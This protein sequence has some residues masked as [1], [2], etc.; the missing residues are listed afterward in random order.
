MS[1]TGPDSGRP[2]A[3]GTHIAVCW[4]WVDLEGDVRRAGVSAAD[5]AALE[6]ALEIAASL[7]SGADEHAAPAEVVVV[8][9]GPPG[10]DT[11][12]REA[13]AAGA[14][15]AVR[16]DGSTDLP[17]DRVAA[18]LAGVLRG[19]DFVVCGD[20]SPDRGSG[21]VPAFLA[22]E[23]GAAQ[24][25]GLIQLAVDGRLTEHGAPAVRALRRLDGGRR[26]QLTVTAPAVLSVEGSVATLRRA[27]LPAQLAAKQ[28][29]IEVVDGPE[30]D[31]QHAETVRPFRPRPRVVPAPEGDG[32]LDRIRALTDAGAAV[33]H[34]E[35]VTLEPPEAAARIV[36]ALTEWGYLEP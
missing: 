24:A 10:A 17:S 34:G 30:A 21:S 6:T 36:V 5:K 31:D 35:T 4:K 29:V 13:V 2:A 20:Y 25:L 32:A 8:A 11:V 1:D 22:G 9:L 14:H 27:P 26:E 3:A 15:R 23:L 28:A 12:L 18:A 33:V 7:D 16:V 19:S